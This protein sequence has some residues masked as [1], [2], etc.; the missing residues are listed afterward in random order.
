MYQQDVCKRDMCVQKETKFR[1]F[2]SLSIEWKTIFLNNRQYCWLLRCYEKWEARKIGGT[3]GAHKNMMVI[4]RE[5]R[6]TVWKCLQVENNETNGNPANVA[7]RKR[8]V[9]RRARTCV[10]TYLP[11]H[12]VRVNSRVNK[13]RGSRAGHTVQIQ[14]RIQRLLGRGFPSWWPWEHRRRATGYLLPFSP[15]TV[16][17]F[18]MHINMKNARC[19][20]RE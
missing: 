13:T 4:A 6:S 19:G 11:S 10:R 2:S 7:L 14:E 12:F 15:R 17:P 16:H 1:L 20:G 9:D 5:V 3:K 8:K 18:L